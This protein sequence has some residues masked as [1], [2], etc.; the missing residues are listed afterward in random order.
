MT[1]LISNAIRFTPVRGSIRC[2][3][4]KSGSFALFSIA[5]NGIGISQENISKIFDK[6]FQV[7]SPLNTGGTGL[8]LSI[9][10]EIVR[11]HGGSIWVESEPENGSTFY[12]TLPLA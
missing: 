10:K 11:A 7:S 9:C 12:F 4:E 1:N 3:V 8:G 5:D 2:K 6:F